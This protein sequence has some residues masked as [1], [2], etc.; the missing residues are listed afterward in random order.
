MDP[1]RAILTQVDT[2]EEQAA[3]ALNH[4]KGDVREAILYLYNIPPPPIK[5]KTEWEERREICDSF[6]ESMENYVRRH[7]T[8]QPGNAPAAA[9]IRVIPNPNPNQKGI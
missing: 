3:L 7:S 8:L 6:E 5:P 1:I 9:P 4:T 2:T